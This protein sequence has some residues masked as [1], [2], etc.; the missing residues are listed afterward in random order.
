MRRMKSHTHSPARFTSS[1][2]AGSAL[3]E[4]MAMNSDS[5]LRRVSSMGRDSTQVVRAAAQLSGF[6]V[7]VEQSTRLQREAAAPD[8]GCQPPADRLERRDAL[9]E[10]AAP[11]RREP[12]PVAL[13]RSLVG[14]QRLE[15]LADAFE[16]DACGLARLD[17]GDAT[18]GH[19]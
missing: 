10:L 16:R 4:G 1:R 18:E 13:R 2:C 7:G 8:A 12:L 11:A 15:G 14:R 9:V 17:Q 3:T 19:R 5:S 6:I